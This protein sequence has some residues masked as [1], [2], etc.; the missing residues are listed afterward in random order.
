[1]SISITFD[2]LLNRSSRQ[3]VG[4]SFWFDLTAGV[5]ANCGDDPVSL[6]DAQ[7]ANL[8]RALEFDFGP[9]LSGIRVYIGA[10]RHERC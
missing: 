2:R 10:C 6:S 5:P 7:L 3:N 4:G 1:M 8:R 9:D